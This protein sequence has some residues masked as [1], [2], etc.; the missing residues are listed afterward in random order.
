LRKWLDDKQAELI[1]AGKEDVWKREYMAELCYSSSDRILPDATFIDPTDLENKARLFAYEERIPILAISVQPGYFCCV[2]GVL[3]PRKMLFIKDKLL[4]PQVWNKAFSEMHPQLNEKV[5]ELQEF[6]GKKIRNIVWDESKSFMD[7]VSGFSACRKDPKWQDRGIPL[8]REMMLKDTIC[9][10]REV[11]DFG[12][13]CQNML[14]DE[15]EKD[16]QKNYPLVCTL[17]MIVNEY[18]SMEK[19][20][21]H[22]AKPWDKWDA[23]RIAGIPCQPKRQSKSFFRIGS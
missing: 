18:F 4:F 13:E 14:I 22:D 7:V 11:A 16:V 9:F 19:K 23:F 21:I 15:S 12:L 5:K 8:L 2:L 17:S 6:C 10:S 1:R 20:S 3:I